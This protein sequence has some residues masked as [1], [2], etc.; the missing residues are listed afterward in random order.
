MRA[1]ANPIVLRAAVVLFSAMAAFVLGVIAIR[2]LR[3]KIA[4]EA[5]LS[6][7]SS[8]S[9]G[10]PL[11][12]YSTV[13]QQLKQQKHEISVQSQAE[14]NRSRISEILNQAVLTNLS[15]GVLVFGATGLVKT[16]NA[17]A[18][19]ILGFASITGMSS[20]DIFRASATTS[21]DWATEVFPDG[22]VGEPVR[23]A[24]ELDAVLHEGGGRRKVEAEYQTPAGVQRFL[25]VIIAPVRGEEGPLLGVTCLISDSTEFQN[26]LRA[27]EMDSEVSAEKALQLRNSLATI[28]GYARRSMASA[29]PEQAA[30]FAADIVQEAEQLDRSIGG[31]L[32]GKRAAQGVA[33]GN[34]D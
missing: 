33:A 11:H 6:P 27:R 1:L 14:Q 21:G 3:R 30:Q 16:A 10:L 22:T 15:T 13:I 5:D 32:C 12:L 17:A 29:D 23:L 2:A 28:S 26:I 9:E 8:A 18:K 31:F 24:A 25:S 19:E 20:A 4:D 34:S 7:A